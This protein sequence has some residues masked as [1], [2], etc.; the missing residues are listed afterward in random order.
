MRLWRKYTPARWKKEDFKSDGCTLWPDWDYKECCIEHD[1]S[2]FKGGFR[3][4]K[5]K[6]DLELAKCVGRGGKTLL[7]KVVH[8]VVGPLMWVG[9]TIGGAPLWPWRFRWGFGWEYCAR[10]A[11]ASHQLRS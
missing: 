8:K 1:R 6:A 11:K 4:Q 9:V 5:Y 7:G 3:R 10:Y 2:Y